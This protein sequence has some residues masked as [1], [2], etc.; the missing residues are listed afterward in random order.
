MPSLLFFIVI[1][2]SRIAKEQKN[3]REPLHTNLIMLRQIAKGSKPRAQSKRKQEPAS[4][5]VVHSEGQSAR[6]SVGWMN[7]KELLSTQ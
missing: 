2:K 1:V 3:R 5:S 6:R 4:H 7:L